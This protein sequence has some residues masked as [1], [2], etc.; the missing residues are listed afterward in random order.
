MKFNTKPK[1]IYIKNIYIQP[2]KYQKISN[3]TNVFME[4]KN[5]DY[6]VNNQSSQKNFYHIPKTSI[7]TF[8][9]NIYPQK[10]NDLIRGSQYNLS[11]KDIN[12]KTSIKKEKDISMPI[13]ANKGYVASG[14]KVS[15]KKYE[16][17]H[18]FKERSNS[19]NSINCFNRTYTFF[20][21]DNKKTNITTKE[22]DKNILSNISYKY[23]DKSNISCSNIHQKTYNVRNVRNRDNNNTGLMSYT[24]KNNSC[25]CTISRKNSKKYFYQDHTIRKDTKNVNNNI[26][27]DKPK[28]FYSTFQKGQ[29]MS[30][31]ILNNNKSSTI[32]PNSCCVEQL[33][34]SRILNNKNAKRIQK[35]IL[36][37]KKRKMK[38]RQNYK[39][40]RNPLNKSNS[41]DLNDNNYCEK[42]TPIRS[43]LEEKFSNTKSPLINTPSIISN[44]SL[45][46][47]FIEY[48]NFDHPRDNKKICFKNISNNC[49]NILDTSNN[50]DSNSLFDDSKQMK[51]KWIKEEIFEQSAIIIQSVFRGFLVRNK[52]E[53]FLYNCK[54]YT[55]AIELLEKIFDSYL[56]ENINT[57]K[58]KLINYL[59]EITYEKKNL[60]YKT[61]I[62]LK[63]CKSF[64]L[65][66]FPYTL[67]T[68]YGDIF[69]KNKFMELFLHEE[70]GER[71]NIIKQGINKEKELEKKHKEEL[72]DVNNKIIKLMK[73]NNI[74]KN[75]NEKNKINETKYKELSLENKKKDNI[76]NIITND[77][78][79]LAKK[80]KNLKDKI[81]NLEIVSP[82]T[83]NINKDDNNIISH[84]NNIKELVEVYRSNYL[85]FLVKKKH[86]KYNN[87][88]RKY[89]WKYKNIIKI[90]KYEIKMNTFLKEKYLN[91]III[92]IQSNINKLL[93]NFFFKL[94]YTGLIRQ[95][96]AEKNNQIKIE[97]LKNI[98]LKKE[99]LQKLFLQKYFNTFYTGG[100]LSQY[101]KEKALKEQNNKNI[102]LHNLKKI[103]I[104]I[105]KRNK[106]LD[107]IQYK[108]YFIKWTL[109]SRILSM[110]AV[111]DEKK[112]KKRQKQR[113]KRKLEKN[114]SE[115]KFLL[116]TNI[117][118]NINIIDKNVINA[119]ISEKGKNAN[120][121][122]KDKD[123]INYLEH[124]I[125]TDFSLADTNNEI[126]NDKIIKGTEKL[127]EL[128]LKA[129]IFYK[130][131]GNKNNK[132]NVNNNENNNK[133]KKDIKV[134][135]DNETDNDEDSGES[136]FGI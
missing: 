91:N 4:N 1:C 72:E 83:I 106:I 99:N 105:N 56:I 126:K 64:K 125:T 25:S 102:I 122:K 133:V 61:N 5:S 93:R 78:Q 55:K 58:E 131:F 38:S 70:I 11:S 7:K 84:Y 32:I 46:N 47:N 107:S 43:N 62:N 121:K 20:N 23:N 16:I 13:G 112:R 29:F 114:K 119:N 82:I 63:S 68:E 92:I 74:L 9:Q 66:Y 128:F 36:S 118:Q 87:L 117:S 44:D 129:A 59:K 49:E 94:Y 53:I 108:N 130:I 37:D 85:L 34:I 26:I 48:T 101:I 45:I 12:Y 18:P 71:F 111:T 132:E 52:L 67:N 6:N 39:E 120:N 110:K 24:N 124:T 10:K 127:N 35:Y 77:N 17:V 96:E 33:N 123:N 116:S 19:E 136:S 69:Y 2:T 30:P 115:K 31:S 57:E 90:E 134:R 109:I 42:Y 28:V 86:R 15:Q 88:L 95:K 76:I 113:T 50:Y 98:F 14:R 40:I 8:Y 22:V 51:K 21:K 79:N 65:N 97:K 60:F 135:L 103:I 75:I 27:D 104:S 100:L 54:N 81:N 89:F 80:L 41:I 3:S 73:E